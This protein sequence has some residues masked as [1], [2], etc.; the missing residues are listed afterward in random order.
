MSKK[1]NPFV[2]FFKFEEI[3]TKTARYLNKLWYSQSDDVTQEDKIVIKANLIKLINQCDRKTPNPMVMWEAAVDHELDYYDEEETSEAWSQIAD[4]VDDYRT[5]CGVACSNQTLFIG[6]K[7]YVRD[8][9][10]N[11]FVPARKNKWLKT[12]F[13]ARIVGFDETSSSIVKVLRIDSSKHLY[14]EREEVLVSNVLQHSNKKVRKAE[15]QAMR[16]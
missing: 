5:L 16:S 8:G 2:P 6:R 9:S 11:P 1:Q 4:L 14:D 10:K 7:V 3:K 13:T 12:N 15:I